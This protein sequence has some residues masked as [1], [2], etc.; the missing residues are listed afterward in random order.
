MK[1]LFRRHPKP[2][3]S[4]PTSEWAGRATFEQAAL[5]ER[6]LNNPELSHVYFDLSWDEVAKYRSQH[7]KYSGWPMINAFP[8]RFCLEPTS[9]H[10]K[11]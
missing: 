1:E 6:A 3:S 10:R 9:L 2:G 11:C 5:I 4:G 8:D 7:R